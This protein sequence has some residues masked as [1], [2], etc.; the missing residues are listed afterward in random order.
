MARYLLD[1]NIVSFVIKRTF[2]ALVHRV[3]TLPSGSFV[4]SAITEAEIRFGLALAPPEA[5]FRPLSEDF[6]REVDIEPWDSGCAERYGILAATQQRLGKPLSNFDAMI[7]AH[8]LA[9]DFVLVSNDA[10]FRQ[11]KGLKLED[12]TKGPQ[13]T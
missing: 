13:R 6:L 10:V 5:K 3:R 8:A 7:A 2:P 9:H 4:L 12:W 1:T 11:I